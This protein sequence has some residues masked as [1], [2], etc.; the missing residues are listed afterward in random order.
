MSFTKRQSK[1]I[2]YL[3]EL[4]P[5]ISDTFKGGIEVLKTNHSEKIAQSAH[6]LREVVYLLT[7]LD[8]I[9]KLG[10]IRTMSNRPYA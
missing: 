10:R 6:S 8:E 5:K 1:I 2:G 9:R 3:E 4:D 7:R